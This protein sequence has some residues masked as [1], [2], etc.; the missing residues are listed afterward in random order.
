MLDNNDGITI[1]DVTDPESPAYCFVSIYGLEC[2]D[3]LNIPL[4]TPLSATQY[5]HGYYPEVKMHN[6]ETT[7]DE[8][9]VSEQSVLNTLRPFESVRM[10]TLDMLSEVWPGEYISDEPNPA[11]PNESS[12]TTSI[13]MPPSLVDMT[14]VPA[15]NYALQTGETDRLDPFMWLPGNLSKIKETLRAHNPLSENDLALLSKVIAVE[16]KQNK[17]IDLSHFSPTGEQLI[18]LLSAH[19]LEG[20]EV[21]NISNMQQITIDIL[22]QLIPL[23]PKLRRLVLLHTIPDTDILSLLSESP[24]LFYRID[25][26][27]HFAFLRHLGQ[28]VYPAAFSHIITKDSGEVVVASVPYFT[29]DQLV[30]GLTDYLSLLRSEDT[31]TVLTSMRNE[32]PLLATYASAVREPGRSWSERI[33]PFIPSKTFDML[34]EREGWFFAWSAIKSFSKSPSYRYAFAKINKEAMEECQQRIDELRESFKLPSHFDTP[35]NVELDDNSDAKTSF[36]SVELCAKENAIR[37][38]Y[39]G[40]GFHL[41]DVNSFFQE[42]VKEGRPPP[43]PEALTKLLEL[44]AFLEKK[45]FSLCLMTLADLKWFLNKTHIAQARVRYM[46]QMSF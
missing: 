28:A 44:F 29:P 41:F 15:I 22:R 16:V 42:L 2:E 39:A 23:L 32:L 19:E 12:V 37:S 25:S 6:S 24:E 46:E 26:I 33:V 17:S 18:E 40:R 45:D 31:Y 4:L 43:S 1:I 20:V 10:I 36:L 30:Q 14:F 9:I 34:E 21:L 8:E 7:D 35:Q 11:D 3:R 27:I 38:E 13:H 5:L